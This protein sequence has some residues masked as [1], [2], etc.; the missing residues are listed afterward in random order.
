MCSPSWR[1]HEIV[2]KSSL[3]HALRFASIQTEPED[4][5]T[6]WIGRH[7]TPGMQGVPRCR[8]IPSSN[9]IAPSPIS[10]HHRCILGRVR[11][12]VLVV[13]SHSQAAGPPGREIANPIPSDSLPSQTFSLHTAQRSARN[14][15]R[16]SRKS[17]TERVNPRK[18]LV[19]PLRRSEWDFPSKTRHSAGTPSSCP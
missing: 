7:R 5:D 8:P 18:S 19:A 13:S 10:L 4:R 12:P 11:S 6:V 14:G 9:F 3:C 17:T 15:P 2:E 16:A 1:Q